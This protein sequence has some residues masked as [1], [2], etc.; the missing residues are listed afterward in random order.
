VFQHSEFGHADEFVD[1]FL[2]EGEHP[3]VEQGVVDQLDVVA[4]AAQAV[5]Q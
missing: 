1:G 5:Q 2:H 3:D 4:A